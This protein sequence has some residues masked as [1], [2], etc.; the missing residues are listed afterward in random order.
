M[1]KNV[2]RLSSHAIVSANT[3][4]ILHL[5][6]EF[7]VIYASQALQQ[8]WFDH[9]G[10]LICN[11]ACAQFSYACRLK[12]IWN[13]WFLWGISLKAF[14]NFADEREEFFGDLWSF[15][16]AWCTLKHVKIQIN[17]CA[18]YRFL[19]YNMNCHFTSSLGFVQFRRFLTLYA[20]AIKLS[21]NETF[22]IMNLFTAIKSDFFLFSFSKKEMK[23]K[24]V[25]RD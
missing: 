14:L 13:C 1:K 24:T 9:E 10:S 4:F 21:A 25:S 22:P 12:T 23:Q 11:Y 5:Q 19:P 2:K 8:V 18:I 15:T 6:V 20:D 16:I 3:I 7:M 17:I